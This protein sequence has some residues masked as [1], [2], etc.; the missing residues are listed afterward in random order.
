M[1]L[2]LASG[3]CRQGVVGNGLQRRRNGCEIC[4]VASAAPDGKTVH[5][6]LWD[7][8]VAAWEDA[9]RLP[10]FV[11]LRFAEGRRALGHLGR[12]EGRIDRMLAGPGKVMLFFFR[13]FHLR[14]LA[15]ALLQRHVSRRAR[16]LAD[17]AYLRSLRHRPPGGGPSA[18]DLEAVSQDA[19]ELAER[20]G[21]G[22]RLTGLTKVLWP[23]AASV[24]AA[25]AG[26]N[27]VY[28]AIFAAAPSTLVLIG[29]NAFFPALYALL[30]LS[31]AFSVKR[32]L[33]YP[34]APDANVLLAAD[35]D[36]HR[37]TYEAED[38]A[39]K[40]IGVRKPREFPLDVVSLSV[41]AFLFAV[42]PIGATI[43]TGDLPWVVI[44]AAAL[45][46]LSAIVFPVLTLRRRSWR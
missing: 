3:G 25:A 8:Y 15:R 24:I 20:L 4:R 13:F 7:A 39:W 44:L 33:L 2:A 27:S 40:A 41:I 10:L 35:I 12:V 45:S 14:P 1:Q 29:L 34:S 28:E 31:T 38:R 17:A 19:S 46:G 32:L 36:E 16:Q 21:G 11:P 5:A 42:V 18:G 23:V 6:D 37:N 22:G 9:A 43:S 30:F 26:A